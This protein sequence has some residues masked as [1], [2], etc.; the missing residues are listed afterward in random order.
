MERVEQF[1]LANNIDEDREVPT[2]LVLIGSKTGTSLRDVLLPDKL[3]T[4]SSQEIIMTP[5]QHLCP[6]PLEI[7]ERC[8]F[9]KWNQQ[10]R[11]TMLAYAA[12]LKKL[13][14]HCIFGANLNEAS[15]AR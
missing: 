12:D 1:F 2:L 5:R 9:Y 13:A 3:P 15:F 8:R 7:A 4:K 6:K 14:T 10:E 11:E